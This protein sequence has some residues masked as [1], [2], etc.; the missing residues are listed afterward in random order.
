MPDKTSGFC[1]EKSWRTEKCRPAD[2]QKN[3]LQHSQLRPTTFPRQIPKHGFM[4][5]KF[6]FW[7]FGFVW[8]LEFGI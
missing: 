2:L 1:R 8:V 3:A 6:G 5:G 7:S 4:F